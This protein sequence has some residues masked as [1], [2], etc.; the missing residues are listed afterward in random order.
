MVGPMSTPHAHSL[1]A[2]PPSPLPPARFAAGGDVDERRS[3]RNSSAKLRIL[4][5]VTIFLA[6]LKGD[7]PPCS[8]IRG[9]GRT[10]CVRAQIQISSPHAPL[11]A[12]RPARF[13]LAEGG[14]N[15]STRTHM[16][17]HGWIRVH[18][19]HSLPACRP[20]IGTAHLVRRCS[21]DPE[22]P[23]RRRQ[24][25][26]LFVRGALHY[27]PCVSQPTCSSHKAGARSWYCY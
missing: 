2:L 16:H 11:T 5:G 10:W 7:S 26:W 1:T 19:S 9:G 21:D 17:K 25:C 23:L 8:V 22:L 3:G 13:P 27:C 4:L 12:N 6:L 15:R 20:R 18:R 24:C 14:S